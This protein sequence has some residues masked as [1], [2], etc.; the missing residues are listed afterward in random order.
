MKS[1]I[2]SSVAFIVYTSVMFVTF[3]LVIW[4]GQLPFLAFSAQY[5]MGFVA[6]IV[7]R[8]Q[9]KKKEYNEH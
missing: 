5:T 9:Q 8:I 4:F 1:M 6:Y 3:L 2:T 7:K